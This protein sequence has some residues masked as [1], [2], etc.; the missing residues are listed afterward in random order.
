IFQKRILVWLEK[1]YQRFLSWALRGWKPVFFVVGIFALL[2]ITFGGF[3]ASIGEGR[4][5]VEFFPDN[6]PNQI[7][8]YIEYPQG[9]D[10]DKT[11]AITKE[12]ERRVYEIIREDQYIDGNYNFLVES[13]V[14]QVGQG[15]GNP[16]TDGGSAAEMPHRGKITATMREYKYRRGKD[17][18]ILRG[19]IQEALKGIYPGVAISVEKDA[20]GPPAG[21]PINIELEGDSYD[22]LIAAA[23]QMRNYINTKNIA[24]IAELKIDVNKG[25]P[26]MQVVVDRQKA[27]E[28]GVPASRVGTQLRRSIFGEK[29]GIFKK[30]GEDYDI[31]VRFDNETRYNRSALFN[32]NI[33]FRDQATGRIKEVPIS[34]VTKQKNT[35]SFSAIKHRDTR[36]VVTVYSALAPGFTDAQAVVNKIQ[37][38]M[39]SYD[40]LPDG[41]KIDYT[42]Q[43]EEQNKQMAFLMSAF[44]GGLGLIFLILIFQFS[45]ISK[46]TI[47]MI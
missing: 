15:A 45:S 43:I 4:T 3:G 18:E 46:P 23:E 44:F 7:I 40:N 27:G 24:G 8:T 10:I 35:S 21:Y 31:Y 32:Q 16:Q 11:N 9:T 6:T 12:I 38:E 14:S 37:A 39:A 25:K 42:G 41:I 28:L 13:S 33:T 22:D 30:D 36:R 20:V 2:F 19:K 5:K 26:G 1:R 34:A 47:I 29:A 17:S